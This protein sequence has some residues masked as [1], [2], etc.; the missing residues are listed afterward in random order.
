MD[1]L[2]SDQTVVALS[3][4]IEEFGRRHQTLLSAIRSISAG[5]HSP[6]FRPRPWAEPAVESRP[7][8]PPAATVGLPHPSA[9]VAA[10]S[11][12]TMSRDYDFFTDLDRRIEAL[13]SELT[14]S[15]TDGNDRRTG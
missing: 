13:Q 4:A 12:R 11:P 7:E 5:S 6:G 1:A 9:R 15:K 3:D 10:G 2:T 8:P 14:S